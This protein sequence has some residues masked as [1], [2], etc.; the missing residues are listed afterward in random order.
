ML[1]MI[2]LKEG[3]YLLMLGSLVPR[4][5]GLVE[6]PGIVVAMTRDQSSRF[7]E[8]GVATGEPIEGD[9]L[10]A[11]YN[12]FEREPLVSHLLKNPP[13]VQWGPMVVRAKAR[14]RTLR[15]LIKSLDA[16]ERDLVIEAYVQEQ[17]LDPHQISTDGVR[18]FRSPVGVCL[19]YPSERGVACHCCGRLRP[20]SNNGPTEVLPTE[21]EDPGE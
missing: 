11:I 17:G 15:G 9:V 3:E 12:E 18:C 21:A 1:R 19:L 7:L 4:P 16:R 6:S 13:P 5:D 20:Q 8:L 2:Q 10:R 14:Y